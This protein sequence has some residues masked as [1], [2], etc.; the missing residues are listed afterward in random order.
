MNNQALIHGAILLGHQ[1]YVLDIWSSFCGLTLEALY[2]ILN[3]SEDLLV[4][5]FSKSTDRMI[6]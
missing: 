4:L 6:K 1:A 3:Y 2:R 5:N